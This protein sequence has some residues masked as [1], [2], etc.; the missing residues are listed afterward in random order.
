MPQCFECGLPAV[1]EHH[2]VPQSL[3]GTKTVPLCKVCHPRAHGE[4]GCWDHR[5]LIKNTLSKKKDRGE[6]IGGGVPYGYIRVE[7]KLV[8]DVDEQR[9][10][11]RAHVLYESGLDFKEIARLFTRE[12]VPTK[13]AGKI[14]RGWIIR[15]AVT[16]E[17]GYQKPHGY[18]R[19]KKRP[20]EK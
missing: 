11:Q 7:N 13:K 6:Y 20:L 14:W 1:C 10:I 8:K 19:K 16:R 12:G 4:H 3:G 15:R 17:Y 2:V 9:V 18:G 5:Q